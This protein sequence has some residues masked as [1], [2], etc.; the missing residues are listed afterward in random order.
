LG[1]VSFLMLRALYH[2]ISSQAIV[3]PASS[4]S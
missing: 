1:D 4:V 3:R 2:A